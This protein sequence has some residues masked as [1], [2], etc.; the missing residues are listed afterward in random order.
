[1]PPD[2]LPM[3]RRTAV[4]MLDTR[5][6]DLVNLARRWDATIVG[7]GAEAVASERMLKFYKARYGADQHGPP[8]RASRGSLPL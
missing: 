7:H 5:V 8:R 3:A 2:A 4:V 1:M 6:P